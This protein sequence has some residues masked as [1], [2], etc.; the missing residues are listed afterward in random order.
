MNRKP[1]Q[2]R[3]PA[4]PKFA[5]AIFSGLPKNTGYVSMR[6]GAKIAIMPGVTRNEALAL[7]PENWTKRILSP[8]SGRMRNGHGLVFTAHAVLANGT[9]VKV[10]VRV[11]R[12]H[13]S[14]SHEANML[15][16]LRSKGFA[17]ERPLGVIAY[18]N[19]ERYIVTEFIE[20]S[21]SGSAAELKRVKA[22]L[23]KE[24]IVPEDLDNYG[25]KNFAY[26]PDSKGKQRLHLLD[27]EHYYSKRENSRLRRQ[28]ML[29]K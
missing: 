9:P 20:G 11:I 3:G 13:Y 25:R 24:G 12:R 15:L 19:G 2:L 7:R 28:N 4:K 10:R 6:S 23:A 5:R 27:V 29:Q 1:N 17:A 18:P 8:A 14:V 16:F 26:A 22:R 21:Q